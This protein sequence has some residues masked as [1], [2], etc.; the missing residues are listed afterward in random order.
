M[1][2]PG[3]ICDTI[4][5]A[6]GVARGRLTVLQVDYSGGIACRVACPPQMI[7]AP[8]QYVLAHALSD[9]DAP[10]ATPLFPAEIDKASF[11]AAPPLPPNWGPGIELELRGPY[12]RGFQ[13][14]PHTRRLAL[15]AL[16]EMVARLMPLAHVREGRA[17]AVCAEARLVSLPAEIEAQPLS[18]ARDVLAWA[19]FA[20][21]DVPLEALAVLRARLGA[22]PGESLPCPAQALILTPLPCGGVAACGACALPGRQGWKFACR[23][24]P[25]FMLDDVEW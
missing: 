16:G 4:L 5:H 12:G 8:G 6:M 11:L 19:D 1:L 7:P 9:R 13:L 25:V 3:G 24:G 21:F 10:L 2:S 23:D 15:V 22:P 20:A 17:V 14:P 18:A